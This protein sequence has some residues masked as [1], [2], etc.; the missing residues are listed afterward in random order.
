M[1]TFGIEFYSKN[2][3]Q[4]FSIRSGMVLP[5]GTIIR[6]SGAFR[7]LAED[8]VVII[9]KGGWDGLCQARDNDSVELRPVK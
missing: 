4:I 8:S 7:T 5:A 9:H 6:E 3:R 2:G 1:K